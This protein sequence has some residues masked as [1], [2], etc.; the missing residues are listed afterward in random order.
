M[1]ATA[2]VPKTQLELNQP[3]LQAALAAV[4]PVIRRAA[5]LPVLATV[6]WGGPGLVATDLDVFVIRHLAGAPTTEV[7]IPGAKFAE[8]IRAM[9]GKVSLEWDAKSLTLKAGTDH[10]RLVGLPAHEFPLLPTVKADPVTLPAHVLATALAQSRY[11][12]SRAE[13]RPA[14]NGVHLMC[15]NNALTVET[16][17]G[18][19]YHRRPLVEVSP[20]GIDCILPA[21]AVERLIGLLEDVEEEMEVTFAADGHLCSIGMPEMW[22]LF[23]RLV[24]GPYPS[25]AGFVADIPQTLTVTLGGDEWAKALSRVRVMAPDL[26]MRTTVRLKDGTAHFSARNADVGEGSVQAVYEGPVD[27]PEFTCAINA[28]Y[29]RQ[30]LMSLGNGEITL[31]LARRKA[32]YLTDKAGNLALAMPLS[33]EE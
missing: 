10:F 24:D 2:T 19:L 8:V 1:T 13:S 22:T 16:M 7:C 14:L 4:V 30:S 18:H 3:E 6:K 29:L 27:H 9:S 26:N 17:D 11:A 23:T 28:N 32:L 5:S 21:A 31:R 15:V 20:C 12:M 33:E 25:T